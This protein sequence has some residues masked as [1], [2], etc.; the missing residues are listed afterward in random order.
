M[1]NLLLLSIILIFFVTVSVIGAVFLTRI[2]IRKTVGQGSNLPT[3]PDLSDS[4]PPDLEPPDLDLTEPSEEPSSHSP[5]TS[6]DSDDD[7]Q[8]AILWLARFFVILLY[9]TLSL[10]PPILFVV[11]VPQ[12]RPYSALT[13][14]ASPIFW[15]WMFFM[16]KVNET[17]IAVLVRLGKPIK[18]VKRGPIMR[19]SFIDKIISFSLESK[20]EI[21]GSAEEEGVPVL[22]IYTKDKQYIVVKMELLWRAVDPLKYLINRTIVEDGVTIKGFMIAAV[23]K[24]CGGYEMEDIL[25]NGKKQLPGEIYNDLALL[26]F[27]WGIEGVGDPRI[28]DLDPIKIIKEEMKG[29]A[30]AR[31]NKVKTI[32]Q[33]EATAK[34]TIILAEAQRDQRIELAKAQEKEGIV[35]ATVNAKEV[36]LRQKAK[37]EAL[38]I[39]PG[40]E[41]I[42]Y[43][44][45]EKFIDRALANVQNFTTF[46]LKG[47]ARIAQEMYEAFR[48]QDKDKK[49]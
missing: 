25:E 18:I 9:A 41:A 48:G 45:A 10:I 46:D 1:E 23:R 35:K 20:K 31:Y 4:E 49:D 38:G 6:P 16:S 7:S 11:Y 19:Y 14:L 15:F 42:Q 28:I 37:I 32:I 3:T 44:I 5:Q 43:D 39:T 47:L 30:A 21:V 34:Q 22:D 27:N 8:K 13:L 40:E 29:A 2:F 12:A 33:A 24:Y 26:F 36:E 17:E